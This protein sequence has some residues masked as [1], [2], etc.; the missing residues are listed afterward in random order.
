MR[1][2][3]ELLASRRRRGPAV[4]SFAHKGVT[5]MNRTLGK[6]G[7]VWMLL[8]SVAVAACG[9]DSTDG[10]GNNAGSSNGGS[11]HA[12]SSNAGRSGAN[13]SAGRAGSGQSGSGES[14]AGETGDG[15]EAG[16]IEPGGGSGG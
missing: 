10:N 4:A 7:T 6:L 15:G 2:N 14:D 11:N 16:E 13:N 8:G 3:S 5:S 12:G 1:S 9:D